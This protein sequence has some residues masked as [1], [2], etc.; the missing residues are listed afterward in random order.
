VNDCM[1]E[2]ECVRLGIPIKPLDHTDTN[3]PTQADGKSPLEIVGKATFTAV[4]KKRS[5]HWEGYVCRNL[6]SAI[7]CGGTFM[8]RNKV[9][10]E[11]GNKRIVVE[12]KYYILET[13]HL[14]PDP[15][16]EPN[17]SHSKFQNVA[18]EP[19]QDGTVGE[20]LKN[21]DPILKIEIGSG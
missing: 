1:R 3:I 12:N 19:K 21:D 9:A 18:G 11:L 13:W 15:L 16:P 20:A 5:L 2:D 8:E 10:Q 7:L 4:R 14:C 6:Q 17:V